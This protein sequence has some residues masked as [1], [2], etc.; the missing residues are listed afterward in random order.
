[1]SSPTSHPRKDVQTSGSSNPRSSY[2]ADHNKNQNRESD[3]DLSGLSSALPDTKQEWQVAGPR[4]PKQPRQP[5]PKVAGPITPEQMQQAYAM[6]EERQKRKREASQ[7]EAMPVAK[8]PSVAPLPQDVEMEEKEPELDYKDVVNPTR[9]IRAAIRVANEG[10]AG[11][12]F[13][14]INGYKISVIW[15]AGRFGQFSISLR[16]II[17]KPDFMDLPANEDENSYRFTL[18]FLFNI[19]MGEQDRERSIMEYQHEYIDFLQAGTDNIVAIKDCPDEKKNALTKITL[20]V[21]K[22]YLIE[23]DIPP[24]N[25]LVKTKS[26]ELVKSIGLLT[27]HCPQVVTI[28]FNWREHRKAEDNTFRYLRNAFD[29]DIPQYFPYYKDNKLYMSIMDTPTINDLGNGIFVKK[30]KN[31]TRYNFFQLPKKIH[32]DYAEEMKLYEALA[33][34]REGQWMEGAVSALRY[35]EFEVFVMSVPDFQIPGI[36]LKH[37]AV[38]NPVE[39]EFAESYYFYVKLPVIKGG[40]GGKDSVKPVTGTRISFTQSVLRAG[41]GQSLPQGREYSWYGTVVER[42]LSEFQLTGTD[43]CMLLRRPNKNVPKL[44]TV[45][46]F[47]DFTR[48]QNEIPVR[49]YLTV[50]VDHTSSQRELNA[51]QKLCSGDG[52]STPATTFYNGLIARQWPTNLTSVDITAGPAGTSAEQAEVNRRIW[53]ED[54]ELRAKT[55][56]NKEQIDVLR[57]A[58]NIQ[59]GFMAIIGNAGGGKTKTVKEMTSKSLQVG[60]KVLVCAPSNAVVDSNAIAI[61]NDRADDDTPM[62]RLETGA[63][64]IQSTLDFSGGDGAPTSKNHPTEPENYGMVLYA[65]ITEMA[66]TEEAIQAKEAKLEQLQAHRKDFKQGIDVVKHT[67]EQSDVPLEMRMPYHISVLMKR[68]A[69]DAEQRHQA[70]KQAALAE[71]DV[72]EVTK[73]IADGDIASP[74]ELNPSYRYKELL[75]IFLDQEGRLNSKQ[76]KE[77]FR[78]REALTTRV[79]TDYIR[80][81]VCSLNNAGSDLAKSGFQPSVA[82]F[83]EGGHA[84]VPSLAVPLTTFSSL[85]AAYVAGDIRQL[86]PSIMADG[87]SEVA[88][89]SKVSA[90]EIAETKGCQHIRFRL[91]YRMAPAIADLVR[92]F[93]PGGLDDHPSVLEDNDVRKAVRAISKKFYR[94]KDGSEVVAIDVVRGVS[95]GEPNGSSLQNH[96]NIDSMGQVLQRLADEHV[97]REYITVLPYYAGNKRLGYRKLNHDHFREISTLDAFQ[98]KQNKVILLDFVSARKKRYSD[99]DAFAD[100]DE[101]EIDDIAEEDITPGEV[102]TDVTAFLKDVHRLC[103]GLSRPQYGLFI[104]FQ[105]IQFHRTHEASAKTDLGRFLTRL[106]NA[107]CVYED[108]EHFDTS[109][110]ANAER[111]GWDQKKLDLDKQQAINSRFDFYQFV[112]RPRTKFDLQQHQQQQQLQQRGRGQQY[113]GGQGQRGRGQSQLDRGGKSQR[114]QSW[115]RYGQNHR[116]RGSNR[117]SGSGSNPGRGGPGA[118]GQQEDNAM[119]T[120]G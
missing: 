83:D 93:Y 81:V 97:P 118:G 59:G 16:F 22:F 103:M 48:R 104:F 41:T 108:F 117:G 5:K 92:P 88:D 98:G 52:L 85:E 69:A 34:I 110:Q 66:E 28:W 102:F 30:G 33:P 44:P 71:H 42:Q 19:P 73:M 87:V 62:L 3:V 23:G 114:G 51:I 32:F 96:A 29:Q 111:A 99:K 60:H 65:L 24:L 6:E 25:L 49:G 47:L 2:S 55:N 82:Y 53:A 36:K 26:Y 67:I 72:P 12:Q 86:R 100:V 38:V 9:W 63:Q 10:V 14:D 64:D 54:T 7:A 78:E 101:Y 58:A 31:T 119:D 105:G 84:T 89:V 107:G 56:D 61:W 68:D 95:R 15:D 115:Q 21:N 77:F 112:Q 4:K 116:A 13:Q 80:L 113:R 43:F 1:M 79:M 106:H 27:E 20:T 70:L 120:S 50:K 46:K 109:D 74:S 39:K 57:S 40:R 8:R 91:Q 37:Q 94:S 76:R 18:R 11:N 75:G 45:H 35:R 90:L 17:N